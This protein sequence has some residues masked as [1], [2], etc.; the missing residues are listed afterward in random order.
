MYRALSK[1]INEVVRFTNQH[2]IE[3]SFNIHQVGDLRSDGDETSARWKT[4]E[5]NPGV[6]VIFD[7]SDRQ[8]HYIGMSEQD[9]GTRL[10][11]WL[12]KE[13]KVNNVLLSTD[14]ILT[15]NLNEESYMS[16]ALESFLIGHLGPS[17]NIRNIRSKE[18]R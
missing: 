17:L 6:Y 2:R 18:E 12:F 14:I 11:S 16:P 10:Y 15:I 8:V 4:F 1:T 13:N 9:I 3:A 7:V 5:K